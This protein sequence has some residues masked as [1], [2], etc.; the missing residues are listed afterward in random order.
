MAV[1]SALMTTATNLDNTGQPIQRSGAPGTP[2]DYG[3][4][5]VRPA[6]A[7]D[8]GLVYE[9]TPLE[10][11]Q[12][13]CGIGQHQTLGD[14]SDVCDL[15][16]QID[17]SNLNYASISVGDLAA[18]QTVTRT[19]SN[20]TNQASVYVPKVV[21]PAG[22][23][24][25]VTPAV[26]TVLPRKSAS[27][28]VEITRTSAAVGTW[29][30]GSLTLADLRGHS[31]RSAIAV[32]AANVSAVAE[33]TAAG[34]ARSVPIPV[35]AA[36]NGNL[37][38]K[39]FGLVESQVSTRHLVGKD[40]SAFDPF[41]PAESPTVGKFTVTVPAGTKVARFSTFDADYSAGTD[42]DMYVYEAGGTEPIGSST[43]GS[44]EEGVTVSAAGT[45]DI[46]LV[47]FALPRGQT[48]ND[49]KLHAFV[50]GSTAAGNLTVTPASQPVK[51]GETRSV[52]ATWTGLT[53]GR[54]Y[55][56]VVEYGRSGTPMGQ[57]VIQIK[58]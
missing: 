33:I 1:K 58:A 3:N 57:T 47:Q 6:A 50:V 39:P 16:G 35:R 12:Y 25:K 19:V 46:Y 14:G 56:G 4:G 43:G 9:S 34:P 41:N 42:L 52:T 27:Y 10:W 5:H 45:Y 38:A 44:A 17:P 40:A 26:L 22:F 51:Q 2:L 36:F 24:V 28:T 23:S 21:A 18:K 13:T 53:S 54:Y 48:E 15:L 20:A 30:F 7:F 49:A 8:P 11:F 31:V 32:R 37:T 29:S 55:L